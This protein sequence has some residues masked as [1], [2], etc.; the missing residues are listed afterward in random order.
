MK[1]W[2]L[3]I[4]LGCALPAGAAERVLLVL[5]DSLSAGFGIDPREGWVSLLAERLAESGEPW[6]VV[7]ASVSGETTAGGLSRLPALLAEHRPSVVLVALGSNDGL[8]GFGFDH[9]GANLRAMTA[10]SREAGARVVLAGGMLPPNYGAA[11]ADAFH[12]LFHAVAQ[13]ADVPLVPFLLEQVAEDP[14]L[15]QRDGYHPNAEAQPRILATVWP[16]LA[17]VLGFGSGASVGP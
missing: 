16:V 17:P 13:G 5:G 12:R 7:N 15:M 11:Y 6:R 9:I 4:M 8:R 10:A 2:L 3:A 14:D 1:P